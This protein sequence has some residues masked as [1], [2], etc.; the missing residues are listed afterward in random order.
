MPGFNTIEDVIEDLQNGRMVVLVDERDTDIDG[1]EAV[2]EGELMML[3]EL[4]TAESI[5]FMMRR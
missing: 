5:N 2:G 4:A 3:A 1:Q